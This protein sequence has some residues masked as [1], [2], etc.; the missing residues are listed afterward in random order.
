MARSK[1]RLLDTNVISN[2]IRTLPRSS[3][4]YSIKA[5]KGLSIIITDY[6]EKEFKSFLNKIQQK[7]NNVIYSDSVIDD[8]LDLWRDLIDILDIR[9]ANLEPS[10]GKNLGERSLISIIQEFKGDVK[11]VSNDRDDI[12]KILKQ[13]KIQKDKLGTPFEFYEEIG[14]YWFRGNKDLIKYLILANH[15]FRI[16]DT[17]KCGNILR[18][19]DNKF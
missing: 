11:I 2:I 13:E 16:V 5:P 18:K 10:S 8:M 15:D 6:V 1:I 7:N 4:S 19:I 14:K 9:K 3:I 12:F 17:S